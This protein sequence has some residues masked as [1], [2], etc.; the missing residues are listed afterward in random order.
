MMRQVSVG[1][2]KW[3]RVMIMLGLGWRSDMVG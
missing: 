1:A 2:Q 3:H